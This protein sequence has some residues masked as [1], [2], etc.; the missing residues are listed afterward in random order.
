MKR[1]IRKISVFMSVIFMILF[2]II[3]YYSSYLPDSFCCDSTRKLNLNTTL[4]ITARPSETFSTAIADENQ[5]EI[6]S[7]TLMLMDIIPIK[8][9]QVRSVERPSLTPCGKP[10]GI[11][12]IMDGV[13]V[14]RTGSV[15]TENGAVSPAQEADIREGDIICSINGKPV[16]SNKDIEKIVSRLSGEAVSIETVRDGTEI[17]S[18]ISPARSAEDGR[19][20]LGIWVRDS[21]AGI[22]T[23]TYYDDDTGTFGGLGHPVCDT[24]T[25]KMIPLSSG[26]IMDVNISGVKKG[27]AGTPGEL[28]GFFTDPCS[29]GRLSLNSKYGVFGTINDDFA[30]G[31]EIPMALKQEISTGE[32]V[33][34]STLDGTQPQEYTIEIQKIDYNCSDSS[35][36]MVIKVTDPDLLE[37]SGGIVQGMSGSPI[38]QNNMLVGAVTHVFVNDPSMGYAVFCEN[39]YEISHAS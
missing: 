34:Y 6:T 35:R 26:E 10:F 29:C 30:K 37:R 13:M 28:R 17:S 27:V 1:S 2:S 23:V 38:I 5:P 18:Q 21:S 36:N 9:A 31:N 39:M 19:Y 25:G 14:V 8:D 11:K 15:S 4:S 32:A 12:M 7:V 22:G 24:D 33:I 3:F 16:Y 20:R